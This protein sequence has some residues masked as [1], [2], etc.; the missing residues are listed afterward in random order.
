MDAIVKDCTDN[1]LSCTVP[2]LSVGFVPVLLTVNG[3]SVQCNIV[4]NTLCGILV[5]KDQDYVLRAPNPPAM[6]AQSTEF[7][8]EMDVKDDLPTNLGAMSYFPNGVYEFPTARSKL[9]QFL[10]A[11]YIQGVYSISNSNRVMA[12]S[13]YFYLANGTQ[14]NLASVPIVSSMNSNIGSRMGQII[15]INGAGFS[16]TPSDNAVIF[17]G[18]SCAMINSS[19]T[20]INCEL[21]EDTVGLTGSP[22]YV[23]NA[24]VEIYKSIIAVTDYSQQRTDPI[25]LQSLSLTGIQAST[26]LKYTVAYRYN[27]FLCA[28]DLIFCSNIVTVQ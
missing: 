23:G 21:P 27:N 16:S 7:L 10:S 19:F 15:T 22:P 1:L 9:R 28:S 11:S 3:K 6:H 17:N 24:G 18:L 20:Q 8:L 2:P 5:L 13:G 26:E 14:Y 4:N 25:F 12:N